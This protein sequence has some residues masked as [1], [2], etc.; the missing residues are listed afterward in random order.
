MS[1]HLQ[2]T[3]MCSGNSESKRRDCFTSA[4]TLGTRSAQHQAGWSAALVKRRGSTVL[5]LGSRPTF[6]GGDLL[7]VADKLIAYTSHLRSSKL[8]RG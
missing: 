1:P 5:E 3:I 4:R 2:F 8:W 6:V 7:E